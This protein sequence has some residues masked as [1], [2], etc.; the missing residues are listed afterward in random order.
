MNKYGFRLRELG[1][2]DWTKKFEERI[3][4]VLHTLFPK[5]R[6]NEIDFTHPFIISYEKKADKQMELDVH[7]GKVLLHKKKYRGN[8]K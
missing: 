8:S 6:G 1:F 5:W 3:T 7:I 4:P 2:F